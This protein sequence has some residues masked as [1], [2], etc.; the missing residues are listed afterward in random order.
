MNIL[1]RRDPPAEGPL[2]IIERQLIAE[3]HRS[4]MLQQQLQTERNTLRGKMSASKVERLFFRIAS[5]KRN[6]VA[7]LVLMGMWLV[8]NI[9]VAAATAAIIVTF[10]V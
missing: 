7:A 9:I 6:V 3:R 10:I 4:T 5:S 2:Q 1:Y 8:A